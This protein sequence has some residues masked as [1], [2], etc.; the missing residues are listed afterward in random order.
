MNQLRPEISETSIIVFLV[1][2]LQVSGFNLFPNTLHITAQ[3]QL[4]N[5]KSFDG[6]ILHIFVLPQ[7]DYIIIQPALPLLFLNSQ[8]NNTCK[9]ASQV[10]FL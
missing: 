5:N 9:Y 1:S 3:V 8:K 2:Q 7:Y 4:S 10:L 6:F